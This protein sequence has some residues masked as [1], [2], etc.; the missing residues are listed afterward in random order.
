VVNPYNRDCR[1]EEGQLRR[2]YTTTNT[3]TLVQVYLGLVRDAKEPV[4]V[5]KHTQQVCSKREGRE[6]SKLLHQLTS[7]LPALHLS[8]VKRKV[9]EAFDCSVSQLEW[10][11]LVLYNYMVIDFGVDT[12]RFVCAPN[13]WKKGV[14]SDPV[15]VLVEG[16]ENCPAKVLCYFNH[17]GLTHEASGYALVQFY[18]K[19]DDVDAVFGVPTYYL[20]KPHLPASYLVLTLPMI[21]AHAHM[22]PDVDHNKNPN[23]RAK[24]FWDRFE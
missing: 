21:T 18:E 3:H 6:K 11:K 2:L 20:S 23:V 9:A 10:K 17:H 1:R 5:R 12:L 24:Y 7:T 15:E 13:Y 4:P 19:V 22:I 8:V 16:E 14:R